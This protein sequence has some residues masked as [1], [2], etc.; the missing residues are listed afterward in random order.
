MFLRCSIRHT[1]QIKQCAQNTSHEKEPLD[2]GI[3]WMMALELPNSAAQHPRQAQRKAAIEHLQGK[4][5]TWSVSPQVDMLPFGT[6]IPATAPLSSE[7]PESLT[8]YP[9]MQRRTSVISATNASRPKYKHTFSGM[10]PH[11]IQQ[12]L[13]KLTIVTTFHYYMPISG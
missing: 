4:T 7:I 6:T 10:P 13:S 11:S 3:H 8:N 9:I 12:V 1:R 2:L 5:D